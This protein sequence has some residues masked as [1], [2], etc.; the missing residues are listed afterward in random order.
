MSRT[1]K[2]RPARRAPLAHW[3]LPALLLA[4]PLLALAQVT[5]ERLLNAKAEPQN[6][7]TYSG[8]YMSQR[9]SPLDSITPRN[10]KDLELKWVFQANSLEAFETSPLVVDGVMYLTEPPNTAVALDAR[11]GRLFWRYQY[12]PAPAGRPCCGRVNRG[13]AMLGDRLFMA[14]IDSKLIAIDAKTGTPLWQ[15]QVGDPSLGYSMTLAPLV[16]KDKVIIGVGGGEFGIRGFLAAY[17]AATGKEDWRFYTIPAPGEPGFETWQDGGDAW[18]HGGGPIWVT[19]SYDPEAD[20][21]YWGVGNP[22]PDWS[23]AQRPG[24]NLYTSSVI[25]LDPDTGKLKWHFQFSPHDGHDYDATQVPVLVDLPTRTASS[26]KLMLWGNRNGF[27]YVLDR[28]TGEFVRGKP[29]VKVNWASGLDESG[30]PIPTPVPPG[31]PTFPGN[32]GGTNWY[33][34]SYSPRTQLFYLQSWPGYSSV[35]QADTEPTPYQEGKTFAGGFPSGPVPGR[36]NL[37]GIRRGQINNWTDAVGHGELLAI[38]PLT[39]KNKW[40]FR[41]TDVSSSGIL[42]TGGDVLFTGTRDGYFFALDAKTGA[43][44]WRVT[45]DGQGANGPISYAVDGKQ[46][47]A[48]GSGHALFVFGLRE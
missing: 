27:F 22:G 48:A 8:G 3:A 39:G 46:Y 25:A 7:L 42:T 36:T 12:D 35:Y 15:V 4:S 6:W 5:P 16:V 18:K 13:L 14:T 10:V 17:D 44:L 2:G 47:V 1:T 32:Q 43:L 31:Q 20:L 38:D 29:F 9:Y 11:T 41:T 37:P 24:D 21:T 40:A 23:P 19:G 33:S 45:V 30:R 34:P 26:G 28:V